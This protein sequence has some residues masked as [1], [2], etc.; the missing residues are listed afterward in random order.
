[1]GAQV[2][3]KKSPLKAAPLREPGQSL[4]DELVELLYGKAMMWVTIGVLGLALAGHEWLR[5]WLNSPPQPLAASALAVALVAIAVWKVAGLLPRARDVALGRL[6]EKVVG[7][8]LEQLRV[9]GYQVFH[10]I[11]GD[12]CNVDHVIV[13][14]GGVFVVETKTRMK[15]RGRDAV[16]V[17]DGEGVTVDGLTPDR[18]PIVQVQ[19]A[20]HHVAEIIRSTT[21]QDARVHA[22]VLYPGWFTRSA[23]GSPVWVLNETAF[24]KWVLAEKPVLGDAE[25]RRIAAGIAMHVRHGA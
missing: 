9:A 21:G 24:P 4:G 6:G 17:F 19:A 25:V 12:H 18:D 8:S 13:G 23:R 5:W 1:M 10:D 11:V 2:T 7:Q 20:A 3:E 22:V 16:V 14:P 15:P